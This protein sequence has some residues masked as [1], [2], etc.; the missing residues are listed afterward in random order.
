MTSNPALAQAL[1]KACWKKS[2][3]TAKFVLFMQGHE[4]ES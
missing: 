1:G 4:N 3:A 2:K